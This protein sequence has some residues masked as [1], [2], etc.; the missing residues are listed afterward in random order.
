MTLRNDQPVMTRDG[1]AARILSFTEK[2]A[3]GPY[4]YPILA[5]VE[6]PN[7]VGTWV[8][9]HYM[10]DGRWKSN[11]PENGNDLVPLR[12]WKPDGGGTHLSND[13]RRASA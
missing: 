6:H 10:A 2:H 13:G 7:E 4:H 8:R 5:E 9:W 3:E 12:Q 11:D 1:R